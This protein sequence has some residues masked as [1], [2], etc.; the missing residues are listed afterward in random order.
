M[1][2]N[3]NVLKIYLFAYY[4]DKEPINISFQIFRAYLCPIKTSLIIIRHTE[5]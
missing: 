3:K 4:H 5:E 2:D 1:Q